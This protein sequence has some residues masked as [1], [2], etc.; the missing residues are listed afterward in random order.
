MATILL[1]GE[2]AKIFEGSLANINKFTVKKLYTKFGTFIRSVTV[3]SLSHLTIEMFLVL[4]RQA[5]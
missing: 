2:Y 5:L 3:I 4:P 1:F